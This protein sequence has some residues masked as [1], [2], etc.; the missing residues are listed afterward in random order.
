[1][2]KKVLCALLC[3]TMVASMFTACG[4]SD[5]GSSD[6]GSSG[7]AG[8][9]ESGGSDAAVETS[10]DGKVLNIYCWNEEFKS[11]IRSEERRVG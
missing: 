1:M 3:T 8:G 7:S 9:T 11:R 2:K 4:S 6:A 5:S 10:S